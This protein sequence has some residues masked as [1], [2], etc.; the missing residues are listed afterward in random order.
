MCR[1]PGAGVPGQWC[2]GVGGHVG[3]T[4]SSPGIAAVLSGR[5]GG[6][7]WASRHTCW[8]RGDFAHWRSGGGHR[9]QSW[10]PQGSVDRGALGRAFNG[11]VG[12]EGQSEDQRRMGALEPE[13]RRV[14]VGVSAS[15]AE[16]LLVPGPPSQA[17]AALLAL[18][19]RKM[20]RTR[21]PQSFEQKPNASQFCD[22][23]ESH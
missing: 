21:G 18:C 19:I 12:G 14:E 23:K 22:R 9:V 7:S 2:G 8:V 6:G 11:R 4:G 10:E 1:G 13:S 16:A 3:L 17:S 5:V 15:R 20:P